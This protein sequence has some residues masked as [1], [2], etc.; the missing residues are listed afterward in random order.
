MYVNV[1]VF[2]F[3]ETT[4]GYVDVIA[5]KNQHDLSMSIPGKSYVFVKLCFIADIQ[6][7]RVMDPFT[8]KTT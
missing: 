5:K 8:F 3:S 6:D 1:Y 2:V 7:T 4:D